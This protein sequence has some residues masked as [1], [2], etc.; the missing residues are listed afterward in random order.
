[1]KTCYVFFIFNISTHGHHRLPLYWQ[2]VLQDGYLDLKL[3][4]EPP[5]TSWWAVNGCSFN[6]RWTSPLS[7]ETRDST[8]H[9]TT[10]SG[11]FSKLL[12]SPEADPFGVST[13]NVDAHAEPCITQQRGTHSHKK[14]KKTKKTG[15]DCI[16]SSSLS[17]ASHCYC[18]CCC[19]FPQDETLHNQCSIAVQSRRTAQRC[20]LRHRLLGSDA[21][22]GRKAVHKCIQLTPAPMVHWLYL[23]H[24]LISPICIFHLRA[25][26][27]TSRRRSHL[28]RPW[29]A[30]FWS[31]SGF[32]VSVG[33]ESAMVY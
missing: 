23:R 20:L 17:T 11:L 25:S 3:S 28:C 4:P 22:E 24:G 27:A 21:Q 6:Y 33:G 30:E 12:L 15:G 2:W 26:S 16:Y 31:L 14:N 9:D 18:C 29:A 7:G 5:L 32:G 13:K 10:I 19:C 8:S 1:M